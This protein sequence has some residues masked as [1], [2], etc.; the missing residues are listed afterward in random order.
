MI[1][2]IDPIYKDDVTSCL[3][4]EVET[5]KIATDRNT[6]ETQELIYSILMI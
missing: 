5:I 3:L 6:E 1:D 2:H 4:G